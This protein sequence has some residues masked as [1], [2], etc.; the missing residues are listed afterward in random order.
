MQTKFT[1][2]Q[3]S[4]L[5]SDNT[6]LLVSAGAGSGKTTVLVEKV[7]Q[8]ILNKKAHLDEMLIVTFTESAS[9][10]MKQRL[11]ANLNEYANNQFVAE[12]LENINNADIC[13][14][15]SF[16]QKI[17][18]QYFYELN[19][20]SSFSILDDNNA[21]YLKIQ[22]LQD[23]LQ[24]Y[25]ND[26]DSDFESLIEIFYRGRKDNNL[27]DNIL[28]F[29]EFLQT[30]DDRDNFLNNLAKSCYNLNLNENPA[31]A[32]VNDRVIKE[33]EYYKKNF[34]NLLISARSLNAN[35]LSAF[36]IK[37]ID[38]LKNI[39]SNNNFETN[40]E[41][42]KLLFS[43]S[44]SLGSIKD[45]DQILKDDILN[46]WDK[47]VKQ[48]KKIFEMYC[49]ES[50]QVIKDNLYK[51]S[52]VL[53]KFVKITLDFEKQYSKQKK[54]KNVLDFNDLEKYA[55]E[56]LNKE[57][58]QKTL[59]QKYKY[60]YIDEYQDINSVQEKILNLITN[61]SN[62]IMVGDIKQSIYAFRNSS[63]QIFIDKKN[64]YQSNSNNGQVINLNENFRSNPYILEFI[65]SIFDKV[66]TLNFG[67][68]D[69]KN[70]ARFK[71]ETKYLKV[72]S[73]AAVELDIVNT[74]T[75][76]EKPIASGQYDMSEFIDDNI[77]PKTCEAQ[78]VADKITDLVQNYEI[79]DIKTKS[80]RKIQYK[81]ITILCR[82]RNVLKDFAKLLLKNNIPISANVKESLF[83][84]V[85][86]MFLINFLKLINNSH[87]DIALASVLSHDLVGFSLQELALIRQ[88]SDNTHFYQAVYNYNKEDDLSKKIK[89]FYDFLDNL[90]FVSK[91]KSI[92]E[93]LLL[94]DK[95]YNILNYFLALPAG[96]D[97]YQSV[98]NFIMSFCGSS[99]NYDLGAY[100]EYV[101]N[102]LKE[103]TSETSVI[104]VDDCVKLD[105]IHQSKGL[106]YNVVF[107][108]G[109]GEDFS[110]KSSR[111]DLIKDKDLGL[112]INFYDVDSRGK[113]DTIAKKAILM[114]IKRSEILEESRLLYVALSRAKNHLFIVGRADLTK[115][116]TNIDSY[117]LQYQTNYLSWI[118]SGFNIS[119]LN[120]LAMGKKQITLNNDYFNTQINVFDM[121]D[122]TL[123]DKDKQSEFNDQMVDDDLYNKISDYLFGSYKYTN[124]TKIAIKNSVTSL[125]LNQYDYESVNLQPKKLLVSEHNSNISDEYAKLGTAYH[126]VMQYVDF[127]HSTREDV[128]KLIDNLIKNNVFEKDYLKRVDIDKIIKCVENLKIFDLSNA[129]REKQFMMYINY[130][131]LLS[132]SDIEDKVLL[133][134]VID[135]LILGQKNIIIDYKT[136]K[137]QTPEQL[138][139]KYNFQMKLYKLATEQ[140]ISKKIDN[141][142][143]Y[144]FYHDKLVKVF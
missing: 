141:V 54:Q 138:V 44:S 91:F 50:L 135:L 110:N 76:Q 123:Q 132:N 134:G 61:G 24:R 33:C 27:K 43:L 69:Y 114:N 78:I 130:N 16:C 49:G 112:G 101:E 58:L 127:N 121:Q 122:Y 40:F 129:L 26:F 125:M 55:L 81:D 63:P 104:S 119:I 47:F 142:Y 75:E 87:D 37:I 65:N 18:K 133:Q 89:S 124:S 3:N 71:G 23:I 102:Y 79:Y 32:I 131:Q 82:T 60:I 126:T 92:Y 45:E 106:E 30:Q 136:T 39:N 53:D 72:S 52:K 140:A 94:L 115:L 36:L 113:F 59:K 20:D 15:H 41:S 144:S 13:T 17:I 70:E 93:L 88:A 107:L 57:L 1:D 28:S 62:L 117:N 7:T 139:E 97:R 73:L 29:Y 11:Q 116:D 56:L 108:V 48:R 6:N 96:R 90:K 9:K 120:S 111:Q 67:G 103:S 4:V 84:N 19:I 86:I 5:Q 83:D 137:T 105:T 22:I 64:N 98:N 35:K 51:A 42:V 2:S 14:L 95:Q 31:C 21:K 77:N 46:I 100:L 109:A 10:E 74:H 128:D 68:V 34:E 99:Y 38:A 118:L 143:I 8:Q 25:S 80:P 12:Q 85:D 66:M